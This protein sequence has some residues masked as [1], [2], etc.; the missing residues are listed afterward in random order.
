V[1]GG[2]GG[3]AVV[4]K[5]GKKKRTPGDIRIQKGIEKK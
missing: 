2:I 5:K 1:I 4:S 3:E